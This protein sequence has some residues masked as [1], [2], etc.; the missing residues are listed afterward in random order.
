M[1][2]RY[3]DF[4]RL[5]NRLRMELPGKV[6]SPL[7][8]RNTSNSLM[9][10]LHATDNDSISSE[11]TQGANS[12]DGLRSYLG[13]NA[14]HKRRSSAG[15]SR[16]LRSPRASVDGSPRPA[17]L[18]REAQRVTLRA[19][20]R[21]LLQNEQIAHSRSIADFLTSDPIKLNEEEKSDIKARAE[22]DEKRLEE[23]RQF[24]EIAQRR[25]K[26]LDVHMEKFRREIVENRKHKRFSD[27]R[28]LTDM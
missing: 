23:Q 17:T 21:H 2:R 22:M 9:P 10:D 1:G 18:Y 11:S 24:F 13:V 6:V 19:F 16:S 3:S 28:Y 5:H 25:A 8:R 14:G 20:L 27:W 4:A 12:N 26:E 7:P 15:S